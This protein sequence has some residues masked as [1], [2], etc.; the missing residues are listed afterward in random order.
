MTS[1]PSKRSTFLGSDYATCLYLKQGGKQRVLQLFAC[2]S[3]DECV[4]VS[5]CAASSTR[6][7][8]HQ[9]AGKNVEEEVRD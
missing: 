4:N 1:T 6:L 7:I 3:V 2:G 5:H 8:S 9:S